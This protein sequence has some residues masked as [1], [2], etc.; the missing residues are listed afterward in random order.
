MPKLPSNT[1]KKPSTESWD[2]NT[3][4][5]EKAKISRSKAQKLRHFGDTSNCVEIT[6]EVPHTIHYLKRN[7]KL[8]EKIEYYKER[9]PD[10]KIKL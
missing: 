5:T 1:S 8:A 6:T 7:E 4:E 10:A 2:A 9:Y 3:P